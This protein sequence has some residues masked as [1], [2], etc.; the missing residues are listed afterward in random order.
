[1][2]VQF[3]GDRWG[4]WLGVMKAG[5]GVHGLGFEKALSVYFFK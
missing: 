4:R 1:M 3:G 5:K 2:L